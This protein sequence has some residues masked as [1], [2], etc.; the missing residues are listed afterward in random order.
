MRRRIDLIAADY[1]VPASEVAKVRGRLKH[2]DALCF[3]QK[4]R[5]SL[6][7]LICAPNDRREANM[8]RRRRSHRKRNRQRLAA[9][10]RG[11]GANAQLISS[12]YNLRQF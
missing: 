1:G 8:K 7:W 11:C 6:D 12:A 3:A 5:I 2:D 4:Y 10:A 9:H